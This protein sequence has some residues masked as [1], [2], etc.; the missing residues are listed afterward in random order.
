MPRIHTY[1]FNADH[2]GA[3]WIGSDAQAHALASEMTEA[4]EEYGLPVEFVFSPGSDC[5][6]DEWIENHQYE[7][8]LIFQNAID[9]S[10]SN[11]WGL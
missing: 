7:V 4:A 1:R 9:V 6:D 5:A 2:L 3:E 11:L 8:G 10:E